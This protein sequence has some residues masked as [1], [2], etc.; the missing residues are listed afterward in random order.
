MIPLSNGLL[1]VH[2]NMVQTEPHHGSSNNAI[3]QI[4]QQI[5]LKALP[6]DIVQIEI[7]RQSLQIL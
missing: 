4:V 5:A 7:F 3:T 2:D 6:N 1:I